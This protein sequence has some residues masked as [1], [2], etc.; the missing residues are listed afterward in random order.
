MDSNGKRKIGE[1]GFIFVGK[2][3]NKQKVIWLACPDC[4]KERW[5]RVFPDNTP[6]YI[7]CNKCVR[8]Y[9]QKKGENNPNW[10]GGKLPRRDGYV[11]VYV[12]PGD[13]FHEMAS[14]ENRYILEHRLIMAKRIGRCL[15]PWEVVHHIDGNRSNNNINNL[16]LFPQQSHH[17]SIT[18]M[19]AEIKRL[20][21]ENKDLRRRLA[22]EMP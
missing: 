15:F 9:Q 10:K 7:Y 6:K 8:K 16:A 13:P 3:K 4:K 5:V 11:D 22:N 2:R 19:Q 21:K 20:R 14:R 17:W 18:K 12:A 1:I